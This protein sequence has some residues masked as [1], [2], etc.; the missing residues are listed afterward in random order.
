MTGSEL[1]APSFP[2]PRMK[3]VR[4]YLDASNESLCSE[5]PIT[6]KH[7]AYECNDGE[8]FFTFTFQEETILCGPLV[9][10]LAVSIL[11]NNDADIF[12]NVEKILTNGNVGRQLTVPFQNWFQS[13]LIRFAHWMGL[14]PEAGALFYS[15]PKGQIRVSRRVLDREGEVPGFPVSR[16]E[17]YH[18][19]NEGE[20]VA[21]QPMLTPIGMTFRKGE[22]LRLRVGGTDRSVFPPVDQAT[23]TV[24]DLPHIN[25]RGQV[26]IHSGLAGTLNS[27]IELPVITA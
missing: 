7:L 1:E 17:E 10:S 23:L 13:A 5:A 18:P 19:V 2:L 22:K 21:V 15:G 12:I 9:L 24:L 8:A 14:A 26:S 4:L 3:S 20:I 25:A 6:K 27:W 16:L 11:G